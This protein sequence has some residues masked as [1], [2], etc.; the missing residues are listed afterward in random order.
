MGLLLEGLDPAPRPSVVNVAAL[1]C[2]LI[3]SF[4][5]VVSAG[6]RW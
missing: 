2:S 3:V 1:F 6:E 5:R 4:V